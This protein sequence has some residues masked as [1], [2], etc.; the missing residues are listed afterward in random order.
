MPEP[1][2]AHSGCPVTSTFGKNRNT[3]LILSGRLIVSIL[4]MG[5][6]SPV[7]S[8]VAVGH[9]S[10]L[11]SF[12]SSFESSDDFRGFSIVRAEDFDCAQELASKMVLQGGFSHKAWIFKARAEDNDGWIYRPHRAYPTIQLHKTP[13][14]SFRTPCLIS[15]WVNLDMPL[16]QKSKGK[17]NDWFSFA[18]LSCDESDRWNRCVLVNI[19]NDGGPCSGYIHLVHVP[20]HGEQ[21]HLFQAGN[22]NDPKGELRFPFNQWVRLDILI[23]FDGRNGYAK[24]WQNV[25]LVSYAKVE[26]GKGTLAQTHFGLYA[27]AAI[28]FGSIFN[29]K[30]RI[31]EILNEVEA[32]ALVKAQW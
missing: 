26:G 24:V 9:T 31:K 15:L 13:G 29:D 8:Q 3:V 16:K 32:I 19:T 11:R 21:I 7:L 12:E 17:I 14:G 22:D 6:C 1:H 25:I 27:S 4:V 18:T 20:K 2:T 28:P 5:L 23:D 10:L 30:L